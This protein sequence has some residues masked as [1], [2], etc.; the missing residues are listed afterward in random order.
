MTLVDSQS[1]SEPR[2][3][4]KR[5]GLAARDWV[6]QKKT[7]AH[8]IPYMQDATAFFTEQWLDIALDLRSTATVCKGLDVTA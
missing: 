3:S 1:G 7:G 6:S 5:L 4:N 8:S 2:I